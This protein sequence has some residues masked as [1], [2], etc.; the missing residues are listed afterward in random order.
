M[1]LGLVTAPATAPRA[2][3][4]KAPPAGPV[5]VT[6]PITAPVP[7]PIAPP[8]SARLP[9][10]YP[11]PERA[12][13]VPTS[14][15]PSNMFRFIAFFPV[16]V[17]VTYVRGVI[18]NSQRPSSAPVADGPSK[19]SVVGFRQL[20]SYAMRQPPVKSDRPV[21]VFFRVLFLSQERNGLQRRRERPWDIQGEVASVRGTGLASCYMPPEY[22]QSQPIFKADNVIVED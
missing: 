17:A 2:P 1:V 15:T 22:L 16:Y 5:P 3:P 21:R 11:H 12:N 4:I 19:R 6:A 7:A 8:E 13:A 18:G 10:V 20:S 9:G 14:I